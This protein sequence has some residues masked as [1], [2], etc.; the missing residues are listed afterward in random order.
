M[1]TIAK[2]YGFV[3]S[4]A[5]VA[6][7]FLGCGHVDSSTEKK[8]YGTSFEPAR[9]IGHLIDPDIDEASG[10]IVSKCQPNVFWTHNDSGD[11]PFIYAF[12]P[13]GDNLGTWKVDGTQNIDWEDI[14]ER[15]EPDG[16]C[17]I[18]IG[19]IGD[20]AVKRN[21]HS[22][23]RV[24]EPQVSGQTRDLRQKNAPL[25][26]PAERLDFSYQDENQ[27]A[28]TLMVDPATGDIYVLTKHR[29]GPSG[30]YKI[31]PAF[32][33]ADVQTVGRLADIQVPSLPVG[34]LTG[35]DI[36][37]DGRRVALCD[38][39]DG[40]ELSL[41]AGD[42]NFDDIWRQQP[43]RIDLGPRDQGEAIAYSPD[44]LELYATTEHPNPPLIEVRR[45]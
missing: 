24:R 18:Y 5:A 27:N 2:I 34:L 11:G 43:V 13:T 10:L 21:V 37:P 40:Y 38:Y 26:E 25:T 14:A 29:K 7:I 17:R 6:L 35:G 32:G 36:S 23:Y 33:S 39:V 42:T 9:V 30:V 16:T 22:I 1:K 15:R 12:G 41:P 8:D 44:G 31:K 19:E 45:K 20:N 3:I 4:V 28:E